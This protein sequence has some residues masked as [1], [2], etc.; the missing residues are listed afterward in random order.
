[1]SNSNYFEN[2]VG[3][4]F[5]IALKCKFCNHKLKQIAI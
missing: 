3:H 5:D 4:I 1:M 2:M